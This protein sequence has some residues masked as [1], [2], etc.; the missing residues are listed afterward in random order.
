MKNLLKL[1][2]LL[3]Y[4]SIVKSFGKNLNR[5][6]LK[7]ELL[8]RDK[9]KIIPNTLLDI[10]A[11]IGEW[12]KV[13]DFIYPGSKIYAFEPIIENFIEMNKSCKG[14]PNIEYFNVAL[15]AR[16]EERL[17]YLNKFSY[18][19]SLLKMTDTHKKMFP[20]T[21]DETAINLSCQRLDSIGNIILKKPVYV[22]ID[23]QGAEL[24]VLSGFGDLLNKIDMIQVELS[25]EN[26]YK[27]QCKYPELFNFF[28]SHGF[29]NFFQLEPKFKNNK[30]IYCDLLFVK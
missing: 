4:P 14:I 8:I 3:Q 21:K 28:Y 12:S 13:I 23:V 11:A 26:F 27:D 5:G 24:E 6:L 18:S 10:G 29:A 20:H 19:S 2:T 16:D 7:N 22:K 25:F 1:I 15:S 17:F 9:F 30:I